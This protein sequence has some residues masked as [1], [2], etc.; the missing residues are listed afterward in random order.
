MNNGIIRSHY[1]DA[2][3]QVDW[4]LNLRPQESQLWERQRY[5][6]HMVVILHQNCFQDTLKWDC[7]AVQARNTPISLL[8][9]NS[10]KERKKRKHTLR[11][12]I[13][14]N[15]SSQ[16]W[17]GYR[18]TS[19]I[20]LLYIKRFP[21]VHFF[22]GIKTCKKKERKQNKKTQ[23]LLVYVFA[24]IFVFPVSFFTQPAH[25]PVF[26]PSMEKLRIVPLNTN[27]KI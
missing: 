4:R 6:K 13:M 1:H 14:A 23:W 17:D 15:C 21:I 12:L 11:C 10:P 7:A 25:W 2:G 24:C 3:R 19:L 9:L 8:L 22:C 27:N 5:N 16:T 26:P 20:Q 18:Y